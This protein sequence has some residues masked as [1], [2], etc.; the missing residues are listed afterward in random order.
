MDKTTEASEVHLPMLPWMTPEIIGIERYELLPLKYKKQRE[1]DETWRKVQL[2]GTPDGRSLCD[3]AGGTATK[4][5]P[6]GVQH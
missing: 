2:V 5:R 3:R 4:W 6:K 1:S